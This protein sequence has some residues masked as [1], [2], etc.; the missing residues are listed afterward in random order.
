MYDVRWIGSDPFSKHQGES[1]GTCWR[2]PVDVYRGERT[3]LI[4]LELAGVSTK[5]VEIV[6][7]G[8]RIHVR[9]VRR[10][11]CVLEGQRAWSMEISYSRF[12][13]CIE[14]P[15]DLEEVSIRGESRDGM[16]LITID[17][18]ARP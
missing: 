11:T 8:R 14:L 18:E 1:S 7:R 9:G 12:E 13:R 5:D 4:K 6:A 16:L 2:P 15:F 10:D 17:T 3:W